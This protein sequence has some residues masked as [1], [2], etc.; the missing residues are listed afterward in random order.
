MTFQ[1]FEV[2]TPHLTYLCLGGF[3]VLFGMFS[4]FLREKL[5][6]GEACW[7]FLFG[8]IIGPYGINIFNP[9][10]WGDGSDATVNAIT[11]EFTRVVLA[12]GVFAIGVELPMTYVKRHWKSL[13]FML[14]PVMA[15]GWL[16]AAAFIYALVPGL[17]FLS[18]LCIAACLSPTDPILAAAVVGGKYADKHVPAHVRHLLASECGCNDGAAY[19]FLFLS[20]YLI[21]DGSVG[22][23]MRDWILLLWLYQIILGVILGSVIGAS[24]RYLMRFC[25]RHDL[26]DRH[27]AVAQYVSLA[28]LT[29]G[30]VVILGSDDLLAAFSCGSAFA[31]DGFFNKQTEEAVFSSV[32]DLLFNIASFVYVGAWMPFGAFGNKELT[33][34]VWRL[35]V[36]AILV[37]LLKRLPIVIA[38]YRWIPDIKTFREAVFSGHFGPIGVGAVFISTLAAGILN[39]HIDA[40]QATTTTDDAALAQTR[41][42]ARVIQPVCAFMVVCSVAIHGLSIPSFSLTRRLHTRTFSRHTTHGGHSGAEWATQARH[43]TRGD[44]IVINKD[45]EHLGNTEAGR[46]GIDRA[47]RGEAE[48]HDASSFRDSMLDADS[49]SMEEGALRST[50]CVMAHDRPLH[51]SANGQSTPTDL[52]LPEAGETIDEW[53]EGPHRIIERRRGPGEEVEVEVIRDC[54]SSLPHFDLHYSH[55]GPKEDKA[56]SAKSS[57]ESKAEQGYEDKGKDGVTGDAHEHERKFFRGSSRETV[58]REVREYLAW[59][60]H[61]AKRF[62]EEVKEGMSGVANRWNEHSGGRSDH[63]CSVNQAVVSLGDDDDDEGWASDRSEPMLNSVITVSNSSGSGSKSKTAKTRMSTRSK[64]KRNSTRRGLTS[65]THVVRSRSQTQADTEAGRPKVAPDVEEENRGRTRPNVTS[66]V[67]GDSCPSRLQPRPRQ[68]RLDSIR[69]MQSMP[70]SALSSREQ[71]PAR[72]VRFFDEPHRSGFATPR[73][74]SGASTPRFDYGA[75]S[76]PGTPPNAD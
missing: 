10:G 67:P 69:G 11:L 17:T 46:D 60:E 13:F 31:W 48:K 62:E 7:A 72:S 28:M 34:E 18:A 32:I 19:P 49:Q 39:D 35:V 9:R 8:V 40:L 74:E 24:F 27:S 57:A 55:R 70:S 12:I 30:I 36:I 26:V 65:A 38:L 50:S 68:S 51:V 15:W 64:G 73:R 16:V 66:I 43:V 75:G 29:V 25:E 37:L 1:P 23:A 76:V 58:R 5:Y 20:L 54:R 33:L 2:S 45:P 52:P 21:M 14:G 56:E 3:V 41:L 61:K 71:S 53:Q 4:L 22:A 59:L 47:E 42:L 63:P 44:Q 6:I